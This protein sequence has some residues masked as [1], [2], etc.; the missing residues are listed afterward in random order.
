MA[1]NIDPYDVAGLQQSLN[2]SATR[3]STVWISFLIFALYLVISAVTVTH[4]QL[5]LD[6]R[7]ILVF[8]LVLIATIRSI[9]AVIAA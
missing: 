8:R 7:H 6:E 5:L 1:E 3:V 2:D 9:G 4:R